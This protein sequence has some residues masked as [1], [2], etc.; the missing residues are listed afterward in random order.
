MVGRCS[1]DGSRSGAD[2]RHPPGRGQSYILVRMTM[3]A[4][5]IADEYPL[6]KRRVRWLGL[7]FF[8]VLHVVGIIGTPLYIY[9][10]GITAPELALFFFFLIATGMSTTIGYH[11]LF[12][13]NTFK[14]VA[15]RAVLPAALR[16][17]HVRGIR[18]EV[19]VAAPPAPSLHRHRARSLRRQQG[20]LARAHRLDPVLA[21]PHQLRQREGSAPLELVC[22]QHDHHEWWSIGGGVVLPMLIALVDRP[23][24]GRDSSWPS[25]CASSSSCTPRSA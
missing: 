7:V 20:L 6:P 17:G 1:S 3:G 19:V 25:A 10:R 13:H 8:I 24:A 11:R 9:Y 22:H 5:A 16:R 15:G 21:P 23:S 4:T 12:A 14:T 2:G 18:A